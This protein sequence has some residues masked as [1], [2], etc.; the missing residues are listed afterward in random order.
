[1]FYEKKNL[2]KEIWED[3]QT[4]ENGSEYEYHANAYRKSYFNVKLINIYLAIFHSNSFL[5]INN[6]FP[7]VP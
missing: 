6:W 5:S 7:H 3:W 2:E 4:W 1:M